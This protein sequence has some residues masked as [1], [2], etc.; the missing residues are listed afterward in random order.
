[1]TQDNL[2]NLLP[3]AILLLPLA[4]F[5]VLA[6]FGDW[7][8]DQETEARAK[9]DTSSLRARGSFWA[10]VMGCATVAGASD[11]KFTCAD[12]TITGT[13]NIPIVVEA[14]TSLAMTSRTS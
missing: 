1:V 2:L 7:I 8:R 13:T 9:G 12:F 11:A 4:G 3:F 6:L 5:V 14:S 10:M